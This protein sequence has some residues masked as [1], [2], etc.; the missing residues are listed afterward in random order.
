MRRVKA[1]SAGEL[2]QDFEALVRLFPPRAIHDEIEYRN[3]Q[4]M[5]DALTNVPRLTKGQKE[6]LDTLSILMEAY[7]DEHHP[8][9]ATK[10]DPLTVLRQLMQEHDMS[11][12]DLGRVLGERSLGSK[13]LS[14]Q[15]QLSKIHIRRLASRF[16][17]SAE[18]FL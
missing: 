8:I 9:D 12:S 1:V 16:N 11:A 13:I 10:A 5:I 17:V 15:R 18:L 3:T 6:Y 4:Q 7:E 2:P 14:G